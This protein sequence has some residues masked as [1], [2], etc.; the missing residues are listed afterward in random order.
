MIKKLKLIFF[1]ILLFVIGILTWI[2]VRYQAKPDVMPG[3]YTASFNKGWMYEKDGVMIEIADAFPQQIAV[4]NQ[5]EV[6]LRNTLP[7]TDTEDMVLAFFSYH[8]LIRAYIDGKLIYQLDL[9]RDPFNIT[10]G[11]VWNRIDIPHQLRGK[12]IEIHF[13]PVFSDLLG[14]QIGF[15]IGSRY[16]VAEKE[17]SER[18]VPFL[19]CVATL[20]FGL[21]FIARSFFFRRKTR[22]FRKIFYLGIFA[23][24]VAVWSLTLTN[25]PQMLLNVSVLNNYIKYAGFLFVPYPLLLYA[26]ESFTEEK[27]RL[28]QYALRINL[29]LIVV[30]SFLHFTRITNFR[31]MLPVTHLFYLFTLL[32][33]LWVM[34]KSIHREWGH[35]NWRRW[36]DYIG[37]L[38]ITLASAADTIHYYQA[39]SDDN[40]RLFRISVFIF[41][42]FLG[43]KKNYE[44]QVL[45]AQGIQTETIRKM[46]FVDVLTGIR[47]RAAFMQDLKEIHLKDFSQIRLVMLDMNNLKFINDQFGHSA[48]DSCIIQAAKLISSVFQEFGRSYRLSGDEFCSILWNCS[49]AD[50]QI[51]MEGLQ[52]GEERINA[53]IPYQI[54]I[55]CGS[56]IFDPQKDSDLIATLKRA[57]AKMYENK[58]FLKMN[59]NE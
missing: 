41:L 16:E 38:L 30:Q 45:M 17:F 59:G 40:A 36:I 48:G 24:A 31:R 32:I 29:L 51:C 1:L 21:L 26:R 27:N 19:F 9:S 2:E 11:V 34:L 8:Q 7:D 49:D 14:Y 46:A 39:F 10:P 12:T 23:T 35:Q 5:D 15:R 25:L 4:Q 18:F 54:Q 47:N 55:A 13:Q 57:D 43:Y 53:G 52:A 33:I 56:S 37:T 44:S 28:I 58:Q 42:C 6:I 22:N 20:I 3:S 50:Y